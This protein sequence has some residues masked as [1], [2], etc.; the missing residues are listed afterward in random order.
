MFYSSLVEVS[1]HLSDR[2]NTLYT[3]LVRKIIVNSLSV[4]DVDPFLSIQT[5]TYCLTQ[6]THQQ[7]LSHPH[8]GSLSVYH[9]SILVGSYTHT[10]VSQGTVIWSYLQHHR[11]QIRRTLRRCQSPRITRVNLRAEA[12]LPPRTSMRL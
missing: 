7:F 12:L 3:L 2:R 9:G 10:S 4:S 1:S 11:N 5:S 8:R 6:S